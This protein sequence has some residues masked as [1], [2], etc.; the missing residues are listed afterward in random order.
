MKRCHLEVTG[1][2]SI[3]AWFSKKKNSPEIITEISDNEEEEI[4]SDN[5]LEE[6]EIEE[7]INC[8]FLSPSPVSLLL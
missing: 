5:D 3:N 8:L 7:Q 6:P 1:Q 4:E 2:K